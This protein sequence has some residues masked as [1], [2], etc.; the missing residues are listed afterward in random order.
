MMTKAELYSKKNLLDFSINGLSRHHMIVI[1]NQCQCTQGT[2]RS[3]HSP[4]ADVKECECRLLLFK[5]WVHAHLQFLL[6]VPFLI[7]QLQ[8]LWSSFF[9]NGWHFTPHQIMPCCLQYIHSS[10]CQYLCNGCFEAR[11]SVLITTATCSRHCKAIKCLGATTD[12]NARGGTMVLLGIRDTGVT[13]GVVRLEGVV[14]IMRKLVNYQRT[15][16]NSSQTHIQSLSRR[17]ENLWT[18]MM[19]ND[20]SNFL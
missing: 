8:Q 3:A 11:Q 20:D 1:E 5:H 12:F 19:C 16:V 2:P 17:P 4:P 18:Y 9:L 13:Q 6:L 7:P 15:S 14:K 10:H